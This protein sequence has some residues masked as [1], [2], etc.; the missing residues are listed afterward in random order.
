M[1]DAFEEWKAD[2]ARRWLRHVRRLWLDLARL[3]ASIEALEYL[4]Q[5]KGIDYSKPL[6]RSSVYTDKI[7]DAVAEI[8][9]EVGA[10]RAERDDVAREQARAVECLN[11]LE[12]EHQ[13][14]VLVLHY[15]G[16]K[17]YKDIA[18]KL[19]Y[20]E[21]RCKHLSIEALPF[22]YDVMPNE[23]RTRIPNATE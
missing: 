4:A 10:L 11:R 8:V 20:S 17:K 14:A 15:I 23:W 13:A 7:A 16:R 9:E 22:V 2:E 3:D 18:K 1:S 19:N 21:S 6:V 12:N 5:P